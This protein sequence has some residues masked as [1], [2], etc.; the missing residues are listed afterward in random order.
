VTPGKLFWSALFAAGVFL[1]VIVTGLGI[2]SQL[3][4]QRM[5]HKL[6]EGQ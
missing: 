4:E 2:V 1:L 6:R 3:I 5:Q